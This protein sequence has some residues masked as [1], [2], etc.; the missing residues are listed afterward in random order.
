MAWDRNTA[1][2]LASALLLGTSINVLLETMND[3]V[4]GTTETG[5]GIILIEEVVCAESI[6]QL[7]KKSNVASNVFMSRILGH[8]DT[9]MKLIE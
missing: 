6:R 5:R 1:T 3:P 8:Q 7:W 4:F 9:K 2:R